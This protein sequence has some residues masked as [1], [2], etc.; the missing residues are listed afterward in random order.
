MRLREYLGRPAL[1]EF[2]VLNE[3][4][5]ASTWAG[6]R[7]RS[8]GTFSNSFF[9]SNSSL[10]TA[11]RDESGRDRCLRIGGIGLQYGKELAELHDLVDVENVLLDRRR[12]PAPCNAGCLGER[13]LVDLA[14]RQQAQFALKFH[15]VGDLLAAFPDLVDEQ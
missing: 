11:E 2:P 3:L 7:L 15:D 10:S 12:R 1:I 5:P 9:F 6:T 8:T 13:R 14:R 4:F